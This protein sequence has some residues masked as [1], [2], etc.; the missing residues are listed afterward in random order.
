VTLFERDY[1]VG[2]RCKTVRRQGLLFDVGAGVLPDTGEALQRLIKAM[3]IS[4]QF[5]RHS[6]IIGVLIAGEIHRIERASMWSF[7]AAKFLSPRGKMQMVKVAADLL[8]MHRR[9]NDLDL[10][11]AARYDIETVADWC[12]RRNIGQ[13]LRER[14]IFALCRA[15]LLV[16]PEVTSAVDLFDLLKDV[17][18]AK[19]MLTHD[20]GIGYF[21]E[22]AASQARVILGANVQLVQDAGTSVRISWEDQ[23]LQ[24]TDEYDACVVALPG[25]EVS[26]VVPELDPVRR[27]YLDNLRYSQ[28]IVIQLGL[29]RA[30][31]ESSSLVLIPRNAEP[32]I[33]VIALSHNLAVGRNPP[34][35]GILTSYYMSDWSKKHWD[36]DDDALI[37]ENQAIV[38][39]QFGG[40]CEGVNASLVTRWKEALITSEPGTYSGLVDFRS[41]C[42]PTDRIQLAGDYFARASVN[43]AVQSGES[44]ATRLGCCV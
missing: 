31:M 27:A 12:D 24:Q 21:L 41:H 43:A 25:P 3:G 42:V 44:A 29:R 33:P 15:L 10:S 11:S 7:F 2:G 16:E 19:T 14:F 35:T 32:I 13:E 40:W 37:A 6:P 26:K 18:L 22:Q 20:R 17:L 1:A 30:Q 23:G 36:D 38:S 8:R 39:R 28:A 9:L 4:E 34:E 5:R